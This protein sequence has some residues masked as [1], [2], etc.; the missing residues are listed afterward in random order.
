MPESGSSG[1]TDLPDTAPIGTVPEYEAHIRVGKPFGEG[2]CRGGY[3]IT[4]S[5]KWS[6]CLVVRSAHLGP[7]RPGDRRTLDVGL[8]RVVHDVLGTRAPGAGNRRRGEI[9]G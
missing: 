1:A 9:A 8:V 7:G 4:S 3:T 5:E 2:V 6:M